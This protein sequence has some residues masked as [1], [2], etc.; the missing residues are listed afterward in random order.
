MHKADLTWIVTFTVSQ[1]I[2]YIVVKGAISSQST[3]HGIR[4]LCL[5]YLS[6]NNTQHDKDHITVDTA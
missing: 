3:G 6:E 1:L 4:V 5:D 2:I